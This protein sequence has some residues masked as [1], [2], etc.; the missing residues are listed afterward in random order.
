MFSQTIGPKLLETGMDAA[1]WFY[2]G[3][4]LDWQKLNIASESGS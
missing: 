3:E 2:K 1:L 4:R